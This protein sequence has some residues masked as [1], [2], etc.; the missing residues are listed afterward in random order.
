MGWEMDRKA[1]RRIVARLLS[2]ADLAERA[3]GRCRIVCC[4]V[5]WI[6]RPAEAAAQDYL[7]ELTGCD[8]PA[9]MPGRFEGAAEAMRLAQSFRALAA[10]LAALV[11]GVCEQWQAVIPPR[12][13]PAGPAIAVPAALLA[14]AVA[15]E[16]LDTS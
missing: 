3:G 10:A 9:Q 8:L 4:L 7:A 5:L 14:L 16:R 12:R 6:L 2:L 13:E 15:V 1:L 11:E